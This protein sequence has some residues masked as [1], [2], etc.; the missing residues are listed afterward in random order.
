MCVARVTLSVGS[1]DA[2]RGTA[3]RRVFPPHTHDTFAIGVVEQGA[4]RLRYRGVDRIASAGAVVL[5]PPGEV[6]T[7]EPIDDAGWTYRMLYPDTH[8]VRAASHGMLER[9]HDVVSL[10]NPVI[11]DPVLA[12]AMAEM[13][14]AL[15]GSDCSLAVE[16]RLLEVLHALV[17]HAAATSAGAEGR[18]PAPLVTRALEYLHEHFAEPVRLARLAEE[19]GA[20]PFHLIRAFRRRVGIPPHAYLKQLRVNRAQAMLSRGVSVTTASYACGFSDQAH[21]TRIFKSMLGVSPGAY[22]R[23]VRSPAG[24]TPPDLDARR[25]G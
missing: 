23:A 21:L 19:C 4:S 18:V 24:F 1:F 14:R 11:K 22:L 2:L 6:H 16:E 7:G 12:R 25:S 3:V 15:G 13:H 17:A 8:L 20:S 10:A 5:I 9:S